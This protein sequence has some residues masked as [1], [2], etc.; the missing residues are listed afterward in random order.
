M[1]NTYNPKTFPFKVYVVAVIFN[2]KTRKILIGRCKPDP[3]FPGLT[4]AFP[5][6]RPGYEEELDNCI[7]KAVKKSTGLNVENLGAIFAK[8]YPEN[9]K[10]LSVYYLCEVTGGKENP[11][12]EMTELKWVKPEEIEGH[13]TNS[14]HPHLKEYIFNLK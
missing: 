1:V 9:R 14:F 7:I 8:T 10:A 4:W 13:F 3:N 12:D 5:A 6:G 11:G 2:T